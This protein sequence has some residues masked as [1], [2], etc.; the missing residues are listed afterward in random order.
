M[1]FLSDLSNGSAINNVEIGIQDC[2]L[3][4]KHVKNNCVD[5]DETT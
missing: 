3:R 1:N 5:A 2:K 4:E